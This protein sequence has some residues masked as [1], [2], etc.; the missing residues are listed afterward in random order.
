MG[1]NQPNILFMMGDQFRTAS[2]SGMGDGIRTPNIDRIRKNGMFFRE[3]ACTA[4]LCT[5]SRA[6]LATGK[7]PHNCG[8]TVH[9]A[10][11][12]LDQ[13]TYYQMLVKAGYRVAVAG[14]T[15]LHKKT[16]FIGSKGDLPVIHHIGF[17]DPHEMEGKI[18]CSRLLWDENGG[19]KAL[20][21]Y[22]QHLLDKNPELIKKLNETY[23]N[24]LGEDTPP[25][26]SWETFLEKEDFLDSVIG[27]ESCRFL[28]EVDMDSPWHLF[29]S[30]SGPHN[31][32]D[33]PA[34]EYE[35]VKDSQFS[36]PP[37]DNLEGKPEWV[38]KRAA[39]QSA[40][41]T[42]AL[43]MDA[44][45]HYAASV[46]VIDEYVG[47]MLDILEERGLADNTVVVFSAD[48]GEL[49]GDH[50][51]FEK[52][53][54]YEGALRIPMLVHL[55]G[56]TEPLESRE[57]VSLMD[58]APTFLELGQASYDPGDMDAK[59][60]LPILKGEDVKIRKVQQSE[61][62]HTMMLYD[63]KYKWIRSFNDL[64]ELYDLERDPHELCNCISH[65][66][67][68]IRELRKYTFQQ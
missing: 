64:D 2:L 30:F 59:S 41:L 21:P 18:N 60:I 68:V 8:V 22:Q 52:R 20:G 29:A 35:K 45:R 67:E 23:M 14:K 49:M 53:A 38:K 58:L 51:L 56:M 39:Q 4:P 55:P 42:D 44:K 48:H 12:P 28:R 10:N 34:C 25:Y 16:R 24:Y 40:G 15:D 32:W 43:L 27:E 46:A 50:G 11:L 6:S 54:M 57:L 33:P 17:T 9:D 5:P 62:I 26:H 65:H 61:L 3:A 1:K 7:Y 66:P 13:K 36:L 31:P 63:G 47:R 37:H 19:L